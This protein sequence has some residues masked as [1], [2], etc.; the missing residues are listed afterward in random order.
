M[1]SFA[2]ETLAIAAAIAAAA[3]LI[4]GVTG[5]GGAMVMSPPL[6]LLLGPLAAIPIVLLLE[7]LA[8]TPMLVQTRALVK[9]RVIGPIII[10]ACVTIPLGAL[11]LVNSDPLVMRRAIA[12]TVIV[13]ALL[14]LAGWRYSGSHGLPVALGL[15]AVSGTL[16]GATSL[17]GPPVIIYLLAGPDRIETT[18]ANL[19]FFLSAV[20]AAGL[21]GLWLNDALTWRALGA[22][23]LLAPGYFGGIALGMYLFPRFDDRRY[24]QLA[25]A[26]MAVVSLGILLA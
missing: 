24:R 1:D 6:A 17:G 22:A 21:A 2:P 13:F 16:V 20:S 12:V 14:L 25:L 4:R 15:G 9:W 26:L 11:V 19:T 18:R 23:A 10:A 7:A 3:G 8:G 5:F